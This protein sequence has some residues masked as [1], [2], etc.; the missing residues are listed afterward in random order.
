MV[1]EA[2]GSLTCQI[3]DGKYGKLGY[4]DESDQKI[5]K[6]VEGLFDVKVKKVSFGWYDTAVCTE[7]G[8]VYTFGLGQ[9]GQLGHGNYTNRTS[10]SLV[11]ALEGKHVIQVQSGDKRT[12][13]LT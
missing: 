8:R 4:G 7:G 6:C 13:A 2:E 9:Y 12:M 1:R 10:P 5:P 11:K 3:F